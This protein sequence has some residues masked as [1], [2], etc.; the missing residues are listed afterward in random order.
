M[1]RILVGVVVTSALV[2]ASASAGVVQ[3]MATDG[4]K[5]FRAD[6][7]GNVDAP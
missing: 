5:L 6:E 2:A 7:L 1:H 4:N 3:F